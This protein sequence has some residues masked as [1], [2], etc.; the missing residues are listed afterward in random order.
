[1]VCL[2]CMHWYMTDIMCCSYS[3]LA[4]VKCSMI[5]RANYYIVADARRNCESAKQCQTTEAINI[6]NVR[7]QAFRRIRHAP[8]WGVRDARKHGGG[9]YRLSRSVPRRQHRL[10]ENRLGGVPFDF[11]VTLHLQ[12]NL[13]E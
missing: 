10:F 1:M 11:T 12:C 6:V 9:S 4:F 7:T 13:T 5:L 8:M 2:V 3:F